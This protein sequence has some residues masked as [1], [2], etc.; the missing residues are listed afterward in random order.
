MKKT[1][2]NNILNHSL[3]GHVIFVG[4]WVFINLL[5]AGLSELA[6][7]EAYYW[8]YSQSLNWGYFDHPPMVALLIKAGYALFNNELGV[9]LLFVLMGGATLPLIFKLIPKQYKNIPFYYLIVFSIIIVNAHFAGFL[10]LPDIPLIFFTVLFLNIFKKYLEKDTFQSALILG[11]LA[12]AMVYSKYHAGLVIILVALSNFSLFKRKSFYLAMIVAAICMLPHLNWQVN[13]DFPTFSYHLVERSKAYKPVFTFHYIYNQLIITGPLVG[14]FLLFFA[15]REKPEDNFE[16]SLK[17]FMTGFFLFFFLMT[18]KGRV[19]PHWLAVAYIPLIILS[20]KAIERTK[21]IK[22]I[23]TIICWITIPLIISMRILLMTDIL[24]DKCG[25]RSQ[26]HNWDEWA[27]E[28]ADMAGDKP[29]VFY[30]YQYPSKYTFYS[31]NFATAL[32]SIYYHKTQFA[33]LNY[34]DSLQGKRVMLTKSPTPENKLKTSTGKTIGYEFVDNFQSFGNSVSINVMPQRSTINNNDSIKVSLTLINTSGQELS[35]Y[36][37]PDMPSH[38]CYSISSGKEY[39][40]NCKKINSIKLPDLKANDSIVYRVSLP[41]LRKP[42]D[43]ILEFSI[44]TKKLRPANN[45][46]VT[47]IIVK[48]DVE[49]K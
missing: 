18:F 24:P 2:I 36:R 10:A 42:G 3:Y 32:T 30:N 44:K 26:L 7:D 34:E 38:L 27:A 19:E 11:I 29:V 16:K 48:K 12:A 43:Y 15:F 17:F 20:V 41:P 14:I 31:G 13:H 35:F 39:I 25:L 1:R 37:N 33:L 40:K 49:H 5:Q 46:G 9:R 23:V 47:N 28:I 45:E 6:H 4:I 22:K 8:I 21:R